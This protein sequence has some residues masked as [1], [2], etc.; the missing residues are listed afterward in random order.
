MSGALL[1]NELKSCL[2][3]IA[4]GVRSMIGLLIKTFGIDCI[5]FKSENTEEKVNAD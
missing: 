2:L 1:K 4:V 5:I 3:I